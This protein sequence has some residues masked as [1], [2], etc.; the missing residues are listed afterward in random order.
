MPEFVDG[1]VQ[2]IDRRLSELEEEASLLQAARAALL[3]ADRGPG[4]PRGS[5][6]SSIPQL[7]RARGPGRPPGR[8]GSNTRST[9]ALELVRSQPGI[10]VPQIAQELQIAPNYIYRVMARLVEDG[11][12]K[13]DGNG[14][15]PA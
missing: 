12:V 2:D 7:R 5:S 15:N 13:R 1:T 11:E 3:G 6:S 9:Q 14:W 4:R 10:S 8:R